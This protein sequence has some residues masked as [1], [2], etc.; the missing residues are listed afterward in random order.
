MGLANMLGEQ[1]KLQYLFSLSSQTKTR[2]YQARSTRNKTPPL[3]PTRTT[4]LRPA[5][6]G[7][8]QKDTPWEFRWSQKVS[9]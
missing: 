4:T 2:S 5:V 1:Y 9:D 8:P 3:A 7:K 6:T